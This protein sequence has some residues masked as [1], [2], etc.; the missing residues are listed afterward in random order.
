MVCLGGRVDIFCLGQAAQLVLVAR[1]AAEEDAATHGQDGGAPA[2]AVCPG[3]VIVTLKDEHFV[4]LDRIDDEGDDL[5]DDC[6]VKKREMVT[7]N[8]DKCI[9]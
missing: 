7:L 8:T 5:Q 1:Q 4:K 6:W 3:V 9:A 2:K